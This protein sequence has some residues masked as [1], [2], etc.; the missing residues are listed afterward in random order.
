MSHS[1]DFRI[2]GRQNANAFPFMVGKNAVDTDKAMSGTGLVKHDGAI[3]PQGFFFLPTWGQPTCGP[4]SFG[5]LPSSPHFFFFTL[6]VHGWVAAGHE[7]GHLHGRRYT[8][9]RSDQNSS[10]LCQCESASVSVA[11]ANNV[12]NSTGEIFLGAV[13]GAV[14]MYVW[15]SGT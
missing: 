9:H 11:A 14:S 5:G 1:I 8:G 6:G 12:R 13:F 2:R 15:S 4:A 7:S 10:T 3:K